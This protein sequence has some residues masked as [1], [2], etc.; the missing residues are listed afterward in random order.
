[1]L[2]AI[3]IGNTNI[4]CGIYDGASLLAH[5]RVATDRL[6]LADEYAVMIRNLL[7]LRG[8]DFQAIQGCVVSSV[9]PPLTG[10]FRELCR[11]Y[12]EVEP[13]FIDHQTPTGLRY[14]VDNPAELGTDRIAN[15]LAAFRRYGGPVIV[16][17]FGT[18]TTFDVVDDSGAYIGGAIAPGL[19]ISADALFRLAARL[20]QVEMVRPPSVIGT[21]T[22]HHMQSGV[23]YGYAGL[24][25]GIVSRMHR[26]IGI[27]CTVVATG[28]NAE[29]IASET[30]V[31][32][33]VLPYL[34][35]EGLRLIY[36]QQVA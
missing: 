6:R 14:H 25:E 2:L 10:Q 21:N 9:V 8:F 31:I 35:L 24:V 18:A 11:T 15:S 23:I 5:W 27:A 29:T 30:S 34:T 33:A 13:L 32:S 20:Y 4:K 22:M 28:G 16:I 3:D 7:S 12:L 17:S 26:E 19:G 36:E 1:M